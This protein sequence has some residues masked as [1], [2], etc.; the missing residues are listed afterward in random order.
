[1]NE[2]LRETVALCAAMPRRIEDLAAA[3]GLR[4][5]MAYRHVARGIELGVLQ[6]YAPLRGEAGLIL[7]SREGHRWCGSGLEVVALNPALVVHWGAC[8][9][10]ALRLESEFPGARVISDAELRFEEALSG[11]EIASAK[12]GEREDGSARLHRP[13]LVVV[14][15]D[16]PLAIE[17][18]LSP[19]A[20]IRLQQIMG[21][22][23]KAGCVEG[24]RYYVSAGKTRRAV[25]RAV[26]NAYAEERVELIELGM[27]K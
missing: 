2:R 12:V 24:V 3:M 6:R 11:R 9:R 26:R 19:K 13:D 21:G 8:S 27:P 10:L 4:R 1:M 5:A 15:G 20:P 22:W 23:R 14:N 16:R 18:E 17:V 25:E 7:A